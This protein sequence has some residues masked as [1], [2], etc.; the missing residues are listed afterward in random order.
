MYGNSKIDITVCAVIKHYLAARSVAYSFAFYVFCSSL[1]EEKLLK[2][3]Q[4]FQSQQ[5]KKL[6]GAGNYSDDFTF[7]A[8]KRKIPVIGVQSSD[9][10]SKFR[11]SYL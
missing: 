7:H 8:K 5:H 6:K 2:R 4:L 10:T 11:G 3:Y 9:L 1:R